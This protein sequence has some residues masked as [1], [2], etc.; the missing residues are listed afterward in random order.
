MIDSVETPLQAFIDSLGFPPDRFQVDA[1]RSIED[2]NSVV[3]T[4]PT[5][6]GKTVIGEG[7]IAITVA[8]GERAFYTTPIKALSNQKYSDLVDVWGADMVGLLTGDNVINGDAP[9]VVMTTEVLRNMI[10]EGSPALDTLGMVILD[11]VHYLADRSRGSVWEEV[12]IHLDA[13][14]AI[15]CLSATIAN[16]EE[17]TDWIRSRRGPTDLI[18]ETN[19]PVP[20]TSMYM[21]KD[22]HHGGSLDMLEVFTKGGKANPTISRVLGRSRGRVPRFATP[23]RTEVIEFLNQERLLPAI[24]FV[25]SR[26][27]CDA[28][29]AQ[30]AANGLGLTTPEDR[31]AIRTIIDEHV[32]HLGQ[33]D[34]AV[35]GFERWR[36]VLER[37][38]A[39][40]HAG[41]VPAFK[42]TVEELF[43]AGLVKVV[44]ATETLALGIN[45]PARTVVIESLSKFNG[46]SH[47][48]L[49]PSDYT[50][51]TGRAGRRGIDTEGTAVVLHSS[52]VPFSRVSGIAAAGA[53]PLRSSFAPTYNMTV[54]LIARYDSERA[55]ELLSASFAN[56][57][58]V[59]RRDALR[60][61]LAGRERDLETYRDAAA[62]DLGDIWEYAR[63]SGAA[64][65]RDVAS[66]SLYPGAVIDVAGSRHVVLARSWG[67]TRPKLETT[68]A[69]GTRKTL[70]TR[71]LPSGTVVVGQLKLPEPIRA[72]D[73]VYRNE[74]AGRLETFIPFDDPVPIFGGEES[75][76]VATCPDLDTHLGW[77][78]R[79]ERAER[80][81]ARLRRRVERG[82]QD[83]ITAEFD[84]LQIVLSRKG[85]TKGWSLTRA[86]ETLRRLYNELDLLLADTLAN[87]ILDHLDAAQFAAIASIFTFETRGG[88]VPQPP[89]SDF[90]SGPIEAI[91]ELWDTLTEV[92]QQAGVAA[93]REPDVGLVDIIYG[94][95]SGLGLD[96]IFDDEDVRA[97]DF[98]RAARQLLDLLRQIR[99]SYPTYR[100]IASAAI[101]AIDRGIVATDITR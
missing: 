60:E 55:H 42:E 48:L 12:I 90:A 59:Y 30:V 79:A 82:N 83:D 11:E 93:T 38:A 29:A 8:G 66:G 46:E 96:E 77:A 31:V 94:W 37:G 17:F 74:V 75:G 28:A 49:M 16:P 70:Q 87:G 43:L 54:N 51:L 81:I 5:G 73:R 78:T 18:I 10:Y 6:A 63:L 39:A 15:V 67:G 95:G 68:D 80:D 3:V 85:Y 45:M 47:E 65:S 52:Y 88:D 36:S 24:N 21:W 57:S 76:T 97:G 62:C 26:K 35:L 44:F 23:R 41:L 91:Y 58:D 2:G 27:G 89:Q 13:A 22:R 32:G 100:T 14:V 61:N 19:R 20:L 72:T 99:D 92:E 9:I 98:V 50:Q 25:F 101:T 64:R 34:L 56:F 33:D 71:N 4:A 40:H 1:L 53:N 86:G 84:R 69:S 7:A